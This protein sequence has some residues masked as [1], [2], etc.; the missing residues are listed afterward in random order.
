MK[1]GKGQGEETTG[2]AST[3]SSGT[4]FPFFLGAM[5]CPKGGDVIY[6]VES[7]IWFLTA[8]TVLCVTAEKEQEHARS[9]ENAEPNEGCTNGP[10]NVRGAWGF[11]VTLLL[12]FART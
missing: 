12:D 10:G 4:S 8:D 9:T 7:Q 3:T 1:G 2:G 6:L 11:I 5:W